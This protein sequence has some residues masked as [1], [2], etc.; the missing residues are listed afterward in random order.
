MDRPPPE[1]P[2]PS[3]EGTHVGSY[4]PDVKYADALLDAQRSAR[5]AGRGMWAP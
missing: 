4:P 1:V 2:H 3:V 5:E